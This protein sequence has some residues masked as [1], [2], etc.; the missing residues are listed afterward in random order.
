MN[1]EHGD[2]LMKLLSKSKVKIDWKH[3]AITAKID[4]PGNYYLV[5]SLPNKI[6]AARD[7]ESIHTVVIAEGH[8]VTDLNIPGLKEYGKKSYFRNSFYHF[9]EDKIHPKQKFFVIRAKSFPDA[10]HKLFALEKW[11]VNESK[12]IKLW[13]KVLVSLLLLAI[14]ISAGL[15]WDY[16]REKPT[17]FADYVDEFG[18]PKG[19]FP[20]TKKEI[21]G[22]SGHYRFVSS[23]N[24][25]RRVIHANSASQPTPI[26]DLEFLDR[27]MIQQ[28][29]YDAASGKLLHT[30]YL[31]RN[32]KA[33][34]RLTYSGNDFSTID[35]GTITHNNEITQINMVANTVLQSSGEFKSEESSES[36]RNIQRWA[37][38]RN[39]KGQITQVM[40]H[41]IKGESQASDAEGV[42]GKEYILDDDY[43]RVTK[44][45]YLDQDGEHWV[46]KSGIAGCRYEYRGDIITRCEYIDIHG[47]P[48]L[49]I[50]GIPI[51]DEFGNVAY[52]GKDGR[53]IFVTP[54]GSFSF[55]YPVR[56]RE[57]HADE[58]TGTI[59]SLKNIN[60]DGPIESF[61]VIQLLMPNSIDLDGFRMSYQTA[62]MEIWKQKGE[63]G[64]WD[65]LRIVNDEKS[66]R[67]YLRTQCHVSH[68][69]YQGSGEI[70][71]ITFWG[72]DGLYQLNGFSISGEKLTP[73]MNEKAWQQMLAIYHSVKCECPV[74]PPVATFKDDEI[75]KSGL[76]GK[77]VYVSQDKTLY[78]L[79]PTDWQVDE[80][81]TNLSQKDGGIVAML[82]KY[83][84][85]SPL[86]AFFLDKQGMIPGL[87]ITTEDDIFTNGYLS[88]FKFNTEANVYEPLFQPDAVEWWESRVIND[89]TTD[90]KIMRFHARLEKGDAELDFIH[91]VFFTDKCSYILT[92]MVDPEN[93]K[94]GIF[95]AQEL[96]LEIY[97]SIKFAEGTI[98]EPVKKPSLKK[99]STP[100]GEFSISYPSWWTESA[101]E[102][103]PGEYV[104]LTNDSKKPG[105]IHT[106]FVRRQIIP[107]IDMNRY[108]QQIEATMVEMMKQSGLS[109][110]WK[111]NN[112]FD[113]S[114]T[115]RRIL[116]SHFR[117]FNF[118]NGV[119]FR[120]LTFPVGNSLYSL[121]G[122]YWPQ[123][124]HSG[125]FSSDAINA[126][127][128]KEL[129]DI[130]RSVEIGEMEH[131][132]IEAATFKTGEIPRAPAGKDIFTAPDKS[133]Y[134]F[135][136]SDWYENA[137]ETKIV[138]EQ[139]GIVAMSKND[140]SH[141]S[142]LLF[143]L[144][145]Y[146]ESK[147]A[148][149]EAIIDN[150]SEEMMAYFKKNYDSLFKEDFQPDFINWAES[151]VVKDEKT[152]RKIMKF[153]AQIKKD[154]EKIDYVYLL[155][156]ANAY[157]FTL[158]GVVD[159]ES[160]DDGV[161]KLKEELLDVYHSIT[162][163]EPPKPKDS[164]PIQMLY[165]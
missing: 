54:D 163:A 52:L 136:P 134:F 10:C 47:N 152:A 105:A 121:Q 68:R 131:V 57:Y 9:P 37:V 81:T 140:D 73:D 15:A 76:K 60:D 21:A 33:R 109:C 161:S 58:Q 39:D 89:R 49:N 156:F 32:N 108:S 138:R 130:Y 78:F 74:S 31:D 119:E 75:P 117:A 66:G 44:M 133:F 114:D 62:M 43:G 99:F 151:R 1:D 20:L 103:Q 59:V 93:G 36:K 142:L 144:L 162:F 127:A 72:G 147:T 6:K 53:K 82:K 77:E 26:M 118:K 123:E 12:I 30:E 69:L 137:T 150:S 4:A 160:G 22:R 135:Y 115:G 67:E 23:Q 154:G 48:V 155:F 164:A 95:E 63:I 40:Y 91:L 102:K 65:E 94:I 64:V 85:Q 16:Y 101:K 145:R 80:E 5:G 148:D 3:V 132:K 2:Q 96:L 79:Y 42:F 51:F 104:I 149:Y 124:E 97:N 13:H 153:H 158:V 41:T 11:R 55:S 128:W 159:P 88:S 28:L 35:F 116:R 46:T 141:S 92:G 122:I 84:S 98:A 25:L 111:E 125:A 18:I 38:K 50:R 139:D 107:E 34:L 70:L 87:D 7:D 120:I 27:P 17:Y 19:I 14:A 29:I 143:T 157:S 71:G 83:D 106:F 100:D 113:D 24:K 165:Q 8:D 126:V 90:R 129:L 86:L 45:W 112:A 110:E 56:W 146:P 61:T